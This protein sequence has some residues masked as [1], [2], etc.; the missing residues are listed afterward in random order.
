ME[1]LEY[2]FRERI[3]KTA[4]A[5][6]LKID[7]Q[8]LHSFVECNISVLKTET[9]IRYFEHELVGF[10]PD[11]IISSIWKPTKRK[12]REFA[13]IALGLIEVEG[14]SLVLANCL[15][16]KEE[17]YD[18]RF[19]C[20]EALIKKG[21]HAAPAMQ[22]IL[23]RILDNSED[24]YI[25]KNCVITLGNIGKLSEKA[26][27]SILPIL[28]DHDLYLNGLG[29]ISRYSK[30]INEKDLLQLK[31]A[32]KNLSDVDL[33]NILGIQINIDNFDGEG[34]KIL[35]EIAFEGR[36][37]FCMECIKAIGKINPQAE[38]I[39]NYTIKEL[40]KIILNTYE[41]PEIRYECIDCFVKMNHLT[42]SKLPL[43]V[44]CKST[45]KDIPFI[46]I[47]IEDAIDWLQYFE[48]RRNKFLNIS[49]EFRKELEK[50]S[51]SSYDS[52]K[53]FKFLKKKYFISFHM[54][55]GALATGSPKLESLLIKF[56]NELGSE[57]YSQDI[58]YILD[59]IEDTM[60]Q[61]IET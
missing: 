53:Q 47:Y 46:S 2:A 17:E 13:I 33:I 60:A 10:N 35:I 40:E 44:E 12:R 25:R 16:K 19:A 1:E 58:V 43:L 20:S 3:L 32:L 29:G 45:M 59:E 26:I 7:K 41:E 18:I 5:A 14:G 57:T 30:N 4:N 37:E 52:I 28:R 22:L 24:K 34:L 39:R 49:N 8:A 50:L 56:F 6:L 51:V 27:L 9:A 42:K 38:G 11:T 21:K 23:N 54:I 55:C 48:S 31:E 36:N 61:I 15:G